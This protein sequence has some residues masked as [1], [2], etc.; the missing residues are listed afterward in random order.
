MKLRFDEALVDAFLARP[1][2][3]GA[4]RRE[5][6]LMIEGALAGVALILGSG[7]RRR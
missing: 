4:T 5:V 3:A 2:L 1:E 7:G 6:E